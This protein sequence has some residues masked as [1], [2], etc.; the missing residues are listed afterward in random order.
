[1]Q[2]L[3]ALNIEVMEQAFDRLNA[4]DI[5]ACLRL[6]TPDCIINIF[7][8]DEKLAVRLRIKGTHLGEFLG[9]PPTGKT[10]EYTSH[11]IYRFADGKLAEEWICSDN[12]T[13]MTQVGALSKGRLVSMWLASYRLWFGFAAGLTVAAIA[14]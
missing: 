8:V 3:P 5:D 6:M 4:K 7:A 14:L 13:L 2:H 12:I 11:E 10:I 9:N 1:M